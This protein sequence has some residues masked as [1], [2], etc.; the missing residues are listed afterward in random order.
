MVENVIYELIPHLVQKKD[1][2]FGW[3][4]LDRIYLF[5]WGGF[6]TA[7]G[8]PPQTPARQWKLNFVD[9]FLIHSYINTSGLWFR[10]ELHGIRLTL[11]FE[12]FRAFQDLI[13]NQID[14]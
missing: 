3:V 13:I 12:K 5:G 2:G 14:L 11:G 7:L 10:T 4:V 9:Y 1:P 8:F 6:A